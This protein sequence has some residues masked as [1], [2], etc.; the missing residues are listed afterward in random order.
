MNAHWVFQTVSKSV[1]ILLSCSIIPVMM[2][3]KMDTH[4]NVEV[5]SLQPLVAFQTPGY[6][7][8]YPQENFQCVWIIDTGSLTIEFSID[9]IAFGIDGQP[10]CTEFFDRTSSYTAFLEKICGLTQF[11]TVILIPIT[12][13]SSRAKVV[14]TNPNH[15]PRSSWNYTTVYNLF[16]CRE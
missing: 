14:F 2:D 4:V 3:T 10:P 5:H 12:T 8:D 7:N 9:E 11:D 6:L 13:S 15:C 1:L 16:I